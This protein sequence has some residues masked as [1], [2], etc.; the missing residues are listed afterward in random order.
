M[1]TY[2]AN[3]TIEINEFQANN[4]DEAEEIICQYIDDLALMESG[5]LQWDVV[6]QETIEKEETK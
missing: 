1:K 5:I 3:I 4:R 6:N 2:Y